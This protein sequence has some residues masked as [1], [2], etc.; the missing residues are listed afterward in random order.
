M[1]RVESCCGKVASSTFEAFAGAFVYVR[2][3]SS[4]VD[5]VPGWAVTEIVLGSCGCYEVQ[6]IYEIADLCDDGKRNA[7]TD[8]YST[9]RILFMVPHLHV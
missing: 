4:Y 2:L 8:H 6:S 9:K 1:L 7:R 3:I 5:N